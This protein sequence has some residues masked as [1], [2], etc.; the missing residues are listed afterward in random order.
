MFGTAVALGT[1]WI[2]IDTSYCV[3]VVVLVVSCTWMLFTPHGP[4]ILVGAEAGPRSGNDT[5]TQ[6]PTWHVA[7][8]DA[9]DTVGVRTAVL[10]DS[11]W[12]I[13]GDAEN[14]EFDSYEEFE[15]DNPADSTMT[16]QSNGQE[17]GRQ[18]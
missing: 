3:L 8:A 18:D 7:R 17:T 10:D 9:Y 5:D 6:V 13:D 2:V 15:S 1:V 14:S 11:D 4:A 16:P 12:D